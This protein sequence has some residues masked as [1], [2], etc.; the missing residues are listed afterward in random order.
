MLGLD[1]RVGYQVVG[2][3]E[4]SATV[5]TRPAVR[6]GVRVVRS[7]GGNGTALHVRVE[8]EPVGVA[9]G[10]RG[11]V[12]R[13]GTAALLT[14][15]L[16]F[17]LALAVVEQIDLTERNFVNS[18][19]VWL[20][21]ALLGAAWL[22]IVLS[23]LHA[24][25]LGRRRTTIGVVDGRLLIERV[26]PFGRRRLE[27]PTAHVKR[28]AVEPLFSA[29]HQRALTHLVVEVEG[30]DRLGLAPEHTRGDLEIVRDV[31]AEALG[32]AVGIAP[33]VA[34]SS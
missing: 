30:R 4:R 10:N 17:A 16:T 6:S 24:L 27:H 12:R 9:A 5:S 20:I 14:A 32:S 28:V 1:W 22:L 15:V 11:L 33:E 21:V 8:L 3:E 29:L 13:T 2:D 25:D 34:G 19:G 26:G 18:G 7:R 31:L 23:A